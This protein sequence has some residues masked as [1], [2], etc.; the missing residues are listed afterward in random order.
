MQCSDV[1]L[2]GREPIARQT[3]CRCESLE[4]EATGDLQGRAVARRT[5]WTWLLSADLHRASPLPMFAGYSFKFNY[6]REL[7]WLCVD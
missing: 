4:I 7:S 5:A 3:S 6:L 1:N 2:A